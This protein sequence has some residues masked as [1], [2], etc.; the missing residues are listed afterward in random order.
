MGGPAS[1]DD[2]GGRADVDDNGQQNEGHEKSTG[3]GGSVEGALNGGGGGSGKS[4]SKIALGQLKSNQSLTTIEKVLC[5]RHSPR[6][7]SSLGTW[8]K[9]APHD[10]LTRQGCKVT[11][12]IIS[13]Y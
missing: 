2:R 4:S 6:M 3:G 5:C 1:G 10:I 7:C 9:C 12:I 13:S 11:S 8:T